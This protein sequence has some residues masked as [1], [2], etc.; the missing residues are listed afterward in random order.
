[1]GLFNFLRN[2][3]DNKKAKA[4]QD[5]FEAIR[6][7]DKSQRFKDEAEFKQAYKDAHQQELE[8]VDEDNYTIRGLMSDP[9][10]KA[11]WRKYYDT[12][13]KTTI[14]TP[15]GNVISTPGGDENVEKVTVAPGKGSIQTHNDDGTITESEGNTNAAGTTPPPTL[16]NTNLDE[17]KESTKYNENPNNTAT[18]V[19]AQ[20]GR[21][22]IIDDYYGNSMS[23]MWRNLD[24]KDKK[25]LLL[26]Q[27]GTLVGNLSKA[28]LPMYSAYGKS[29][30]GQAI[31]NEKS[32]LQKGL[33]SAFKS[34]LERRDSRLNSQLE[35]QLKI[36]NFPADLAQRFEIAKLDNKTKVDL[37]HRLANVKYT[38]ALQAYMRQNP[39]KPIELAIKA[40]DAIVPF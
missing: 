14:N 32:M 30:D 1:M 37:I 40:V 10:P 33:E 19:A 23:E 12:P 18:D 7:G 28:R 5:R 8:D 34:G 15:S 31:G 13:N 16:P 20:Q 39:T 22:G 25:I 21:Y 17:G 26:D 36:A 6:N 38:T 9:M 3:D 27:I 2:D 29:Y 35:Q 4:A 11:N 24:P